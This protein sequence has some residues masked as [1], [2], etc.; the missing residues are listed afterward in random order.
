MS[1]S[2]PLPFE[3]ATGDEA[4]LNFIFS[5]SGP[6]AI[7]SSQQNSSSISSDPDGVAA[8][9]ADAVRLA[10]AGEHETALGI[11][12]E[13]CSLHPQRPSTFNNRAQVLK[14]LGRP[15]AQKHD[16]DRAIDLAHACID[17]DRPEPDRI[18]AKNTLKQAFLQR[19]V[20]YQCVDSLPSTPPM[21]H[22]WPLLAV[23]WATKMRPEQI[24]LRQQHVAVCW[25]E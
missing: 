13:L 3:E 14:L 23:I 20:Y 6:G 22:L 12:H 8:R 11:L 9:E 7:Y 15:D 25:L 24:L 16:M 17:D 21:P 4:I 2:G 18:R 1:S 10:E 19:S 5:G